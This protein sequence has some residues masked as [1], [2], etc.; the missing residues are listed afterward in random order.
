MMS[1]YT[2]TISLEARLCTGVIL[3]RCKPDRQSAVLRLNASETENLIKH[4]P[5]FVSASFHAGTDGAT[6]AEYVQ[7]QSFA[8]FHSALGRPEFAEH[9]RVVESASEA[10]EAGFFAVA[11]LFRRDGVGAIKIGRRGELSY[12]SIFD[13]EKSAIDS[14]LRELGREAESLIARVPSVEALAF[15]R[16]AGEDRIGLFV[17]LSGDAVANAIDE[18]RLIGNCGAVSERSFTLVRLEEVIVVD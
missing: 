7:W 18:I 8:D 13:V 15:H 16:G 2:Q 3:I 17:R 12:F 6:V 1:P 11:A 5:G 9:V 10:S 14:A 4:F